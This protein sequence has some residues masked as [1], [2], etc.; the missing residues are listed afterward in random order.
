MVRVR[1]RPDPKTVTLDEWLRQYEG[2]SC[3]GTFTFTFDGAKTVYTDIYEVQWRT[4][5]RDWKTPRPEFDR[6]E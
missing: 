4:A 6:A 5:N 2:L 1:K 3:T